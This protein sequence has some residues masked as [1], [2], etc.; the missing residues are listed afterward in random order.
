[1]GVRRWCLAWLVLTLAFLL[2]PRSA[3]ADVQDDVTVVTPAPVPLLGNPAPVLAPG[4]NVAPYLGHVVLGVDVVI[5]PEHQ[6]LWSD[7]KAPSVG[8]LK[9]GDLLT[10]ELVRGAMQEVLGS[11][12]FA[13]ARATLSMEGSGVRVT[14]HATPRK[15]ID[16]IHVDLHGAPIDPDELLRD[17]DLATDGEIVASELPARTA[18][19][20]AIIQRR[21]FPAPRVAITTRKT[22]DPLRVVLDV[23]ASVGAPRKIERRVIYPTG[24]T[25]AETEDAERFYALKAG[26][27]ADEVQL[28]A[29]DAALEARIRARNHHRAEVS[30]DV[31]L[32]KGIVTLRVRA[33]F[34]T[35][36]ET[37]YEGNDHFDR[38][39]L[40]GVLDLEEET[41]RT[42]NHL[43][44]KLTDFYVKHGFLDAEV[45]VETRGKETTRGGVP[46]SLSFLVFHVKEGPR[47]QV[48]ARSYPCLREDDVKKLS[49]GG[50]RSARAIGSE[51]DSYLE[52]E[53]PGS[54][55]I[56]PPKPSA[57]DGM[58]A[59]P[60]VTGARP[61]PLELEPRT[62]YV[63]ETY[64]RAVQ[65]VQ[66]LYRSEGFLSAQV[67]P[68]QVIRRRCHPRSPP[69]ECKPLPSPAEGADICT[70]DAI[71]LPLAVPPLE[72]G[73]TC[74]PDPAH[75]IECEERVWLRIPVKLGPRTQLW[76]V[77]FSGADAI[78]P[79]RLS[80]AADV[81]LGQFVSTVKLEEAR[82]RVVDA[83]K[84]E[85]YAFADVKYSLEQSPDHTRAR[86]RFGVTEGE[87]VIVRNIV[88]RGNVFTRDS[89]VRKRIALLEGQ[90]YRASLV[91]KTEERIATLG[92]F[93]TVTVALEN[94]YVPQRN[95]TVIVTMVERPRQYTELGPGFSTGEGFRLRAEYGH[96][97][98]WGNAI[99][100]TLRLQLAYIP[101]PLIIDPVARDNYR[102]LNDIARL[103][104]RA[105]AGLVFPEI[106]L[107]PLVRAGVD[108]ILVHDL[109]RDFYLTKIAA[110]PNVNYRPI[111][112]LQFTFFQSFE[113][114]NS[115]I[116]QSGSANE[117]LAALLRQGVN[118]TD[119]VRQ[120]LVP[121]GETYA[122][123]QRLLATWDRRDN[124]FN[125]SRGTY[126]V[127]GIEHVDAYPTDVNIE[128]ARMRQ[129]PAPPESHFFKLTQTFG[130][131]IPLPK[132]MRIAALTRLGVNLQLT[133]DSQ[134]YPDRLF[135]MGGVDTMRGWTLNSFIPQD[136]VDRIYASK[137][138][139]DGVPDPNN[140]GQTIPNAEKFTP[141]TQP[142]RGGNLM[143]N[144]RIEL[145]IP[146]RG[147][148][149]TVLFGDIGNLWIDPRYPFEKGVFPMR[150]AVGSGIRVQ[151]PVGP[152]ALDYG[153]NVTR[154]SYEDVG[155]INFAIGLF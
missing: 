72:Q 58:I 105:T 76:G 80:D 91:R 131:Y 12:A 3:A 51:I 103:G 17:L 126:V 147:P 24:A 137:D 112:E 38:S 10:Q 49:E 132:G 109:Q 146:V 67:G 60:G 98:L 34:G 4:P 81:K 139:A 145:R 94:P 59:R 89:A 68:V 45:K 65:H 93:S 25:R 130:G 84:E 148:F 8:V 15:V 55:L 54:D 30:H 74:V 46:R 21:G 33:D 44:Q 97:N 115:R 20:D 19:L 36:Y 144:E 11:G 152:L 6:A 111:G 142:I 77:A 83:Y 63:P 106:G 154:E 104:V 47:V 56:A 128:K 70:Y 40:D 5:D 116:F 114:N 79:S 86:V 64:E 155:A 62:A 136:N 50:P 71:G 23:S 133:A 14:I 37:R 149:E 151:L 100:L 73:T 102:N 143:A 52:E 101:T 75:G 18:R 153:F 125:A 27:R 124:A 119:L 9:P 108:T 117:Y 16:G 28:A 85:G 99:Q 39:T 129:H 107:G 26:M 88:L 96:T 57:V 122:V 43:V 87:R 95:K 22:N 121:D 92:A 66:E 113:F 13:D 82:R 2:T 140:P 1:M 29:A 7:V 48:A 135:F 150:V 138:L 123:S 134:T 32:H 141:A 61:A 118:I 41:D 35:R 110:I 120:L 69:G 90:P 42:P 53:L 78:G 127:S 31:V